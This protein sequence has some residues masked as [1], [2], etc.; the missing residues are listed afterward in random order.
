MVNV[1]SL[2]KGD[3]ASTQ[4]N[5]VYKMFR[6]FYH[7]AFSPNYTSI[8]THCPLDSPIL[9]MTINSQLKTN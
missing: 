6:L 7:L 1:S 4:Q 3:K 9:A 5:T 8:G 2:S